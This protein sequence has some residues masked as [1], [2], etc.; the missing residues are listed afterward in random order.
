MFS[1]SQFLAS[2]NLDDMT[3]QWLLY[4]F[5]TGGI[6]LPSPRDGSP[7]PFPHNSLSQPSS[8]STSSSTSIN[9]IQSPLAL[10]STV[11]LAFFPSSPLTAPRVPSP[12]QELTRSTDQL[13]HTNKV[14][15]EGVD[16]PRSPQLMENR[17]RSPRLVPLSVE[18]KNGAGADPSR[19]LK[20]GRSVD[21]ISFIFIHFNCF[22]FECVQIL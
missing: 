5:T 4:E 17:P 8:S 22:F 21:D 20:S 2:L 1:F 11:P 6:D 12:S 13:Q 18:I 10:S 3:R 19:T 7:S 16:R 14:L 9:P 15:L